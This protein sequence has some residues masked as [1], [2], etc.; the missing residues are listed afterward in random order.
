MFHGTAG[1]GDT[2]TLRAIGGLTLGT[3][4]ADAGGSWSF[5]YTGTTLEDG[6]YAFSASGSNAGGTSPSSAGFVVT[7]DTEAPAV[8]SIVRQS[9]T[10]AV[11]TA[12]SITFRAT[13]TEPL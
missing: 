5:D 9:P 1:P 4:E 12:S 13:F 8:S 3:T 11:S 10:V 2:V 6:D 7:V